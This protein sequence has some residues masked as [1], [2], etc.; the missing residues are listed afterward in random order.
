MRKS[1]SVIWPKR[2]RWT[3]KVLLA[4]LQRDLRGRVEKAYLFG[5]HARETASGESDVDLIVVANTPRAWPE[6]GRDFG[7]LWDRYGAVDL[8]VYTPSEWK[9]MNE[10]HSPVLWHARKHW[11]RVI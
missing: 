7:D 5:S 6:R 3:Q 1:A 8:L 4:R 9:R 10:R 11:K 2:S